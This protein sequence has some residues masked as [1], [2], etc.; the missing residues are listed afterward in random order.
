[1]TTEWDDLAETQPLRVSSLDSSGVRAIGMVQLVWT[2]DEH[3]PMAVIDTRSNSLVEVNCLGIPHSVLGVN[4]PAVR[5]MMRRFY[6][7]VAD[8]YGFAL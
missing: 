4:S 7:D 2:Y 8:S 5:S 1:M 3:H 6:Q